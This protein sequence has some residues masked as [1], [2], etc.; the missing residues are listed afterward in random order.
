MMLQAICL[1]NTHVS[2]SWHWDIEILFASNYNC[3]VGAGDQPL[4]LDDG[5]CKLGAGDQPLPMDDRA[6]EP[7]EPVA[8]W[9]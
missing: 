8:S 5:A 7:R 3:H 1:E 4:P 9:W 6:D 2:I